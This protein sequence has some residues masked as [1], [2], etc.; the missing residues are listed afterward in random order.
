VLHYLHDPVFSHSDTIPKCDRQLTNRHTDDDG[1][2]RAN[3][4][5]HGKNQ[6]T[7][8]LSVTLPNAY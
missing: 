6:D 2:Y 7:R 1:I 3:I 4:A 8:L 5:S